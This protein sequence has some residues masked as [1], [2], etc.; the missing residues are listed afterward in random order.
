M[1]RLRVLEMIDKP[2]LGGGQTAILLL[3]GGLDRDSFE[4]LV[5]SGKDGP[6]AAEVQKLGLPHVPAAFDRRHWRESIGELRRILRDES[7]DVLHTHGGVAGF[8]GRWAASQAK[9]PVVVHTLHGI[10]YLH[11]RNFL[12]KRL[13]IGLERDFSRLTDWVILVSDE[14]RRAAAAHR[15]A[16]E[17]KLVVIKNGIDLRNLPS[18]EDARRRRQELGLSEGLPVVG[19]VARLHRQKGV[20]YLVR[21]AARLRKEFPEIRVVCAGGGPLEAKVRGEVRRLG[22]EPSVLLLG[23][24]SQALATLAALDVFV[25]PSLWEGLPFVLIEAAALGKPIV[26]TDVEGNREVLTPGETGLLV[27]PAD[28]GALAAAISRLLKDTSLSG[29]LSEQ[30][31]RLI[32]PRFTLDRMIRE[33]GELYVGVWKRKHPGES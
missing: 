7:I 27:R 32:P 12:L 6:L 4:V 28:P 23:E 24:T 33:T 3:A 9:T 22:L 5:C 31:G 29:R 13:L 19:T 10:H 17:E 25:L 26:A 11:Y 8:F 16:L 2:S 30:A 18:A 15:L 20:I 14:D 1:S 21:A